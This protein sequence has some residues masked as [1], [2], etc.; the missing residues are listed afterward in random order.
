MRRD[1]EKRLTVEAEANILEEIRLIRVHLE[2]DEEESL[3]FRI[4]RPLTRVSQGSIAPGNVG[5]SDLGIP[6]NSG[7]TSIEEVNELDM[8]LRESSLTRSIT[9][10]C[11]TF[12]LRSVRTFSSSFHSAGIFD[13]CRFAFFNSDSEISVYQLGDLRRKPTSLE[14]LR[15]F[16]RPCKHGECIRNVA[17]AQAY[18]IIVTNK[19]LLVFNVHTDTSIDTTPHGDWDPS[20]LACHKSRAHLVLFLGQCQRNRT[21]KY[22]GQ[23]RVYRYRIDAQAQ[24]LPVFVLT[25]PAN[26]YPKR[27]SFDPDS[28]I[29]TC[30]TRIQNKLLV[31]RLDDEFFSSLEPFEFLKNKYT[32]VSAQSPTTPADRR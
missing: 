7:E 27:I 2:S 4:S 20:G 31:W 30:I 28:Q 1:I 8:A 29:L 19:R 15:V 18:I 3:R 17:S 6:S 9:K 16:N 23:I 10:G 21:N 11:A 22:S 26:D 5:G 32:A 12:S 14:Y 24:E 13:D 25:V